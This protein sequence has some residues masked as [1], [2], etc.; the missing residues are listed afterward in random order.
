MV[1]GT[2]DPLDILGQARSLPI[3]E[4][5]LQP[6]Q[7]CPNLPG[8]VEGGDDRVVVCPGGVFVPR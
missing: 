5:V 8:I 4:L 6:R 7:L 1:V 2:A 3:S